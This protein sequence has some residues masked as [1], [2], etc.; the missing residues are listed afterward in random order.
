MIIKSLIKI[1]I[2]WWWN[3]WVHA[4]AVW[5]LFKSSLDCCLG[6]VFLQQF[7]VYCFLS[8][9]DLKGKQL[10]GGWTWAIECL[11]FQIQTHQHTALSDPTTTNMHKKW[12]DFLFKWSFRF[13]IY[14]YNHEML[15][16]WTDS[17][18]FFITGT[19]TQ[20]VSISYFWGH[21]YFQIHFWNQRNRCS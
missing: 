6:T 11:F 2:S 20:H 3:S 15:N 5:C 14:N 8:N 17:L 9:K 13:L 4:A 18:Q 7:G 10:Q 21:S 19:N 12:I 1:M 16:F